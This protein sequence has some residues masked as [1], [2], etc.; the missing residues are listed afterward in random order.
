MKIKQ[1]LVAGITAL[2]LAGTMAACSDDA[3]K[4]SST[5]SENSSDT[6]GED[7]NEAEGDDAAD[8]NADIG[9]ADVSTGDDTTVKVE[10]KDLSGLDLD[11]VTCVKQGGKITVASG[12]TGG[13]EGLGITM[14]DDEQPT[15]E[16]LSMVVDGTALAVTSMGGAQV[17]SAEVSVDGDTYTITGEATGAGT[18]DPTT[19]MVTKEF[20]VTVTC[21]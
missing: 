13:Q 1:T 20:E 4:D 7:S 21:S 8:G 15:V 14:T 17:G 10:G 18:E 2:A 19:G 16:A 12:A 6:S 5:S 11:S 3:D 9:D